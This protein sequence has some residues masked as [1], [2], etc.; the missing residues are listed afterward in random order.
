[1]MKRNTSSILV[2]LLLLVP[3]L[4]G[5]HGQGRGGGGGGGGGPH[6]GGQYR[7]GRDSQT[8]VDADGDGIDD[9]FQA[10]HQQRQ[11]QK[12][13]E[14]LRGNMNT[15]LRL[16]PDSETRLIRKASDIPGLP[17]DQQEELAE[18]FPVAAPAQYSLE[19]GRRLTI[20]FTWSRTGGSLIRWYLLQSGGQNLRLEGK[21]LQAGLGKADLPTDYSIPETI[22]WQPEPS[23]N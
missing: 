10:R 7:G 11:L 17:K 2:I 9:R 23:A 12:L 20:F 6:G 19:D 15:A 4:A 3:L 13:A 1:M 14:S 22:R 8:F 16:P 18:N 5:L 21:L